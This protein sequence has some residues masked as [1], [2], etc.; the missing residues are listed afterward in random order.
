M[1]HD[2]VDMGVDMLDDFVPLNLRMALANATLANDPMTNQVTQS[3][4]G[5]L[6][7]RAAI[8]KMYSPL[9]G[10]D[11]DPEANTLITLGATEAIYA[12][13]FGHTSSGDEWI[14]IEPAYS[15]YLPIIKMCRG[16]AKV[17][18][19]KLGKHKG[20][21][22]GN[23]WVLDKRE[24]ASLFNARTKGIL[25]NNP[26]NPVG[27]VYTR[28]ELQFIADLAVKYDALVITDEAHEWVAYKPHVRIGS[29]PGMFDRTIT[30]GSATKSFSVS[31]WRIGWAYG[32]KDLINNLKTVHRGSV[33]YTPTL[34][35]IA[36][37][38]GF[39]EEIR[40]YGLPTSYFV[41]HREQVKVNRDLVVKAFLDAGMNL[42]IADGGSCMLVDWSPLKTRLPN[43][44]GATDFAKW[45]VANI[46]ILGL[47]ATSYY[48]EKHQS[49]GE[50]YLRFCYNKKYYNL[51]EAARRLK[52]I[53][54]GISQ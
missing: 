15:I 52:K 19:L 1:G 48:S 11:L 47:P 51:V 33:Y 27:K 34:Q 16:V 2:Y 13:F 28:E 20:E 44:H 31:G 42:T 25:V 38:Y 49:M 5:L 14:V 24:L 4:Y 32:P 23:D 22:H 17:T 18:S 30:I 35:Q 12:A 53:K 10:Q 26:L 36:L 6:R 7:L 54:Y 37:A 9:I 3:H 39:E 8:A 50:D 43:V 46:G 45:L 21:V 40:N 29:L 41:S